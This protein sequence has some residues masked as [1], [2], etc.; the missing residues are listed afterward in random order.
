MKR[1][2]FVKKV[3]GFVT[4][5][6]LFQ[7]TSKEFPEVSD[8]PSMSPVKPPREDDFSATLYFDSVCENEKESIRYFI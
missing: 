2:Q 1:R 3:I 5:L 6:F 4:G 8:F 7:S